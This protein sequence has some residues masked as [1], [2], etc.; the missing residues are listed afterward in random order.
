MV[1]GFSVVLP[2]NGYGGWK[3]LQKTSDRQKA[4]LQKSPIISRELAYFKANIAKADT[5]QKL[6]KDY[7][8]LSFVMSAYR[9]DDSQSYKGMITKALSQPTTDTK[10]FVNQYSDKR[11]LEMATAL[12][13]GNKTGGNVDTSELQSTLIN[14][15]LQTQWETSVGESDPDME[16]ALY[17]QDR[18]AGL[19]Q[20]KNVDKSG[21]FIVMSEAPLRDMFQT[22]FGFPASFSNLDVDKQ[23]QMYQNAA[24][25]LFGSS[26][27]S[28]FQD[29]QKVTKL[30]QRF[31]S[32]KSVS[33]SIAPTNS[34]V[35]LL[36]SF[37]QSLFSAKTNSF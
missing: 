3:L 30:I 15:Y 28:Q 17:V 31:F 21:W 36:S 13:Y 14:K 35:S 24:K 10:S 1:L 37:S 11:W 22:A 5:P 29:P 20:E 9:L 12:G 26:A 32:I 19:S 18:L 34:A 2:L 25:K 16:T 23:K 6:I 4:T 8:L 7:R 27:L 33:N